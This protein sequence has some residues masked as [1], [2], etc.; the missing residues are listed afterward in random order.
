[1]RQQGST[2]QAGL[3]SATILFA[4]APKYF[5][6]RP[7]ILIWENHLAYKL[8]TT[9]NSCTSMSPQVCVFKGTMA[10]TAVPETGAFLALRA[11]GWGSLY[12]WC[13]VDLLSIAVWKAMGSIVYPLS[14]RQ[15]TDQHHPYYPTLSK[16]K[17]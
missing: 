11:L 4:Y 6:V 14:C 12:T 1:P 10:T 7:G 3:Y 15:K 16:L 5:A 9:S 8:G 17:S 2:G 13:G